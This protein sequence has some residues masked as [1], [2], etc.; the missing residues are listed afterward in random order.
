[1][2]KEFPY[3]PYDEDSILLGNDVARFELAGKYLQGPCA[4]SFSIRR[5]PT[6]VVKMENDEEHGPSVFNA[7]VELLER[8]ATFSAAG[9]I[10]S[11]FG[12]DDGSLHPVLLRAN[13]DLIE[14][15]S[16]RLIVRLTWFVY[17]GPLLW[18]GNRQHFADLAANGW[19]VIVEPPPRSAL[20]GRIES[21]NF[22]V[23]HIV[24]LT[25][26]DGVGFSPESGTA[27]AE[28]IRLFLSFVA[29]RW[30]GLALIRG[31]NAANQCVFEKWT[32]YSTD[33]IGV[34]QFGWYDHGASLQGL[35]SG[36]LSRVSDPLW[37]DPMFDTLY[38]Y[39][40]ANH[41]A[42][43]AEGG[44]ILAH[45]ALELLAWTVLVIDE[46]TMTKQKFKSRSGW[47]SA[48]NIVTLLGA[49]QIPVELPIHLRE[50]QAAIPPKKW[51]DGPSAIS[52]IRNDLVHPEKRGYGNLAYETW[53]LALHYVEL[54]I[55]YLCNYHGRYSDRTRWPKF[56]AET[57]LV[58][59]AA[60]ANRRL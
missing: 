52:A 19:H 51:R 57:E 42:S 17:N 5:F 29:G 24:T 8:H 60:E 7:K 58:P 23:T 15:G 9:T 20:L 35:F 37:R 27:I 47:S 39:L 56:V 6:V 10:A 40:I 28:S 30:T 59:W 34:N 38:W 16:S 31:T 22:H 46:K 54:V 14:F 33:C 11:R 43:K 53:Q 26:S 4:I 32:S 13:P 25:R 44:L 1:M 12:H 48:D 50:L 36:F 21:P 55:F 18:E 2:N 49:C 45:S 3:A 41:D